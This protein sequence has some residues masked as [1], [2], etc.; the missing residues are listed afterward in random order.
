MATFLIKSAN[1]TCHDDML[2]T[3]L[4]ILM[5]KHQVHI[6]MASKRNKLL[7]KILPAHRRTINIAKYKVPLSHLEK[8]VT[9]STCLLWQPE[10]VS[11]V[12]DMCYS[13]WPNSLL[14]S[15]THTH[16]HRDKQAQIY[17][18]VNTHTHTQTCTLIQICTYTLVTA[19]HIIVQEISYYY[20]ILRAIL[21][22]AYQVSLFCS[23]HC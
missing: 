5:N 21:N 14:L 18:H 22:Q 13:I 23:Q 7:D 19:R 9:L 15:H 8:T 20:S 3:N 12:P 4:C 2:A 6:K 11:T 1:Y 10:Q 17:T 16:T